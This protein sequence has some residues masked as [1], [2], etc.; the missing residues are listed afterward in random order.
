MVVLLSGAAYVNSKLLMTLEC[1]EVE[2]KADVF[3]SDS[4]NIT[5]IRF[6]ISP[7]W[8]VIAILKIRSSLDGGD[9]GVILHPLPSF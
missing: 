3:Q 9:G 8:E 5:V 4:R 6:T 7:K 2:K 1:I